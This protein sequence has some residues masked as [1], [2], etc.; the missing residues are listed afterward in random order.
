[1]LLTYTLAEYHHAHPGS[2]MSME[3][4]AG[5][6][7][8]KLISA[9]LDRDEMDTEIDEAEMNEIESERGTK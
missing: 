4:G 2:I 8:A 1:M 6:D 5:Y 9:I 7:R 3:V